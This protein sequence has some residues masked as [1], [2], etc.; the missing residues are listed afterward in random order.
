MIVIG[1]LEKQGESV[2][3]VSRDYSI[4]IGNNFAKKIFKVN[5]PMILSK[6]KTNVKNPQL[7]L[8]LKNLMRKIRKVRPLSNDNFALN[9]SSIISNGLKIIWNYQFSKLD[10]W[11]FFYFSRW[12][13][14][15]K[16]NVCFC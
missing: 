1:V 13:W 10:Y 9:E 3:G 16:H 4:L 15:L 14:Y 2:I 7:K 8:E 11:K 5:D 6:A 12:F